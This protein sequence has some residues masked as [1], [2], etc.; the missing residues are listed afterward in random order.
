MEWNKIGNAL[1]SSPIQEFWQSEYK[2][3]DETIC[4]AGIGSSISPVS[5]ENSDID[6]AVFTKYTFNFSSYSI[7]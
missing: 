5:D 4:V 1:F 7:Y 2:A 6:L 3:G